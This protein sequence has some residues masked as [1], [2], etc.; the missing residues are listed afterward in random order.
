MLAY[1]SKHAHIH[2]RTRYEGQDL[3]GLRLYGYEAADLVAHQLLAIL[4][5]VS[6]DGGHD[7]VTWDRLLVHFTVLVA[8]LDL[9]AGVAQVDMVAFLSAE[10]LFTRRFNPCLSGI[11]ART[12]FS[13]MLVDIILVYFR[14]IAKKVASGIDRIVADAADLSPESRK[15]ILQF[16]E[17]HVGLR[18]NLL[19]H[20]NALVTDLAPVLGVFSHLLPDEIRLHFQGGRQHQGVERLDLTRSDQYVVS[21]FVR[22]YY[23]PVPVINYPSGRIDD[24]IDH[25][26]VGCIDL[27]LVVYDLDIEQLAKDDGSNHHQAYQQG[28]AA[29]VTFYRHGSGD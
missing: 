16:C 17:F 20:D 14:D 9:V 15:V 28:S 23:L 19:E 12:V 24:I 27:V 1:V 5:Q 13:R 8:L 22:D 26:V 29:V 7:I 25:R 4:L 18:L 3:S 21:D 6:I 2:T 11:V 10:V